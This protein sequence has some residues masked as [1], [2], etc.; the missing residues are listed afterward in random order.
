[1]SKTIYYNKTI[2]QNEF[3]EFMYRLFEST[4][5][6][7][8]LLMLLSTLIIV[9]VGNE[10]IKDLPINTIQ[11]ER[12]PVKEMFSNYIES[13]PVPESEIEEKDD[14]IECVENISYKAQDKLDSIVQKEVKEKVCNISPITVNFT[15]TA[16]CPCEKCCGKTDGI[17]AANKKCIANHTIAAGKTYPL[18]TV[19]YIPALSN[20]Q[21]GGWYEVEDRGGAITDSKLDIFFDTHEEAIQYGIKDLE[22]YVYLP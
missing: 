22:V 8:V 11:V 2:R 15:T 3:K 14:K 19:M 7:V 16:Y 18:G 5:T 6:V 9:Y 13:L 12:I 21:S 20:T 10:K 17:S 4:L 1:M